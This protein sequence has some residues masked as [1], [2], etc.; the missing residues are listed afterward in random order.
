M[1]TTILIN[2]RAVAVQRM[3]CSHANPSLASVR[4]FHQDVLP[5]YTST[6]LHTLSLDSSFSGTCADRFRGQ[7]YL[8]DESDRYGLPAFK[9]LGAAYASFIALCTR[10]SL[11][12]ADTTLHKLQ[13]HHTKMGRTVVLVAATDGNH[14]RALGFFADAIGVQAKIFIPKGVSPAAE[15]SISK[16][17]N[18]VDVVRLD[19]DYDACVQHAARFAEHDTDREER[20]LIQDTAWQGYTCIPQL[21][22][23]GY[24]TIFNEL[25]EQLPGP[26]THVI[27]PVGVGSL[28]QSAVQFYTSDHQE[29]T[30]VP[31]SMTASIIAVEPVTAGCLATSIMQNKLTSIET[32]ETIMAGLNCG[33]PSLTAWPW[34]RAGIQGVITIPDQAALDAAER[35]KVSNAAIVAGPCGAAPLAALKALLDD[36]DKAEQLG[37]LDDDQVKVVLLMTEGDISL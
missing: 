24:Q 22:V 31:Q 10:W 1:S 27:C 26:A 16:Q 23:D 9:V 29:S 35:L 15:R 37:L 34:L 17:G 20:V 25:Q 36:V 7:V 12:Q 8:K 33:T 18:A 11:D 28:A 14:G 5:G 32:G 2:K 6:G 13:Q 19:D 30:S 3:R 4:R 21:I